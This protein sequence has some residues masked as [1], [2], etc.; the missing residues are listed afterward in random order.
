MSTAGQ[1]R[2]KR[3]RETPFPPLFATHFGDDFLQTVA[4][5]VRLE[6][7]A[8][9]RSV[10]REFTP[11][12]TPARFRTLSLQSNSANLSSSFDASP[13]RGERRPVVLLSEIQQADWLC[14]PG[15]D[16][17]RWNKKTRL[18]NRSGHLRCSTG[19]GIE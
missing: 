16:V 19:V 5:W 13:C 17:R 6:P 4:A 18:T 3:R 2:R 14:W 8:T 12:P 9:P 11:N 15:C 1:R 10:F 7:S